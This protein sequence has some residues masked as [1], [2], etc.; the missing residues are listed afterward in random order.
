MFGC[1]SS[2][3]RP[4]SLP[5]PFM[6]SSSIRT[7]TP[8]SRGQVHLAPEQAP[9]EVVVPDVVLQVEAASGLARRQRARGEGVEAVGHQDRAGH[10]VVLGDQR[11]DRAVQCGLR[12]RARG[13]AWPGAPTA[14]GVRWSASSQPLSSISTSVKAPHA[15][16]RWIRDMR[17]VPCVFALIVGAPMGAIAF[18]GS[19]SRPRGAPTEH[20][21]ASIRTPPPPGKPL[22]RGGRGF[23]DHRGACSPHR[24]AGGCP[25]SRRAAVR[26][27]GGNHM[28]T[29]KK[30]SP[31]AGAQKSPRLL[32][33]RPDTADF[34]DRMFEP[35]LVDVPTHVPLA[36]IPRAEG[37]GARPGR[38]RRLHRVR[39]GDRRAL[40]CC[41]RAARCP[42]P[43]ASA[44]ACSTTWRGATTSGA[45]R[46]TP[47]RA[48]AAR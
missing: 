36:T 11:R 42:T 46:A 18:P 3:S 7:R 4:A 35:T 23:R 5:A 38:R 21:V 43:P 45:A 41:A 47:A 29:T 14:R 32:D 1:A 12:R 2:A 44:R 15:K 40:R 6:S 13:R 33:A 25:R 9:G 30:A 22:C 17:T 34:R 27:L 10:A 39:P 48:A 37:A 24:D 20:A 31:Y 8:R 19:P 16:M 26:P 28:A